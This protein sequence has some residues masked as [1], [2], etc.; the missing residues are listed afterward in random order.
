MRDFTTPP[1]MAFRMKDITVW[2]FHGKL[3][4]SVHY[5][6]SVEMVEALKKA[7]ADPKFTTLEEGEHSNAWKFANNK[8][9]LWAWFLKHKRENIVNKP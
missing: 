3:D 2:I 4:K 5:R 6:R 8:A 9:E 1:A 7:G